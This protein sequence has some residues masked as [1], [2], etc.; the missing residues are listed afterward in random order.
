MPARNDWPA[1]GVTVATHPLLAQLR[2]SRKALGFTQ[3][4][5]A[6]A[7]G[8]TKQTVVAWERGTNDPHLH[9]LA[10]YAEAVDLDLMLASRKAV[11]DGP[12]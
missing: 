7:I 11:A 1:R 10:A 6:A 5:I 3:E 4:A 9:F 2:E 8:T 12:S